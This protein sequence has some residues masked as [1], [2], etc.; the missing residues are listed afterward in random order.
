[1]N[2]K[3]NF[4]QPEGRGSTN[5][6]APTGQVTSVLLPALLDMKA[7]KSLK[8]L[9]TPHLSNPSAISLDASA[10]IRMSTACMQIIVAFVR[11]QR[12]AT[13]PVRLDRPSLVF[14]QA[15]TLLGV[16]TYLEEANP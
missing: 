4:K 6:G 3:F 7:A 2:E 9:L 5:I 10:V 11:T 13:I 16:M 15:A 8:E 14:S 1:M 12:R